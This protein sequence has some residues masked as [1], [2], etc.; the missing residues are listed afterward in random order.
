MPAP[1]PTSTTRSP[2]AK[3]AQRERIAGASERLDGR[4]GN[5]IEQAFVVPEQ[6]RQRTSD[7]EMKAALRIFSDRRVFDLIAWRSEV[8]SR[9]GVVDDIA[10]RGAAPATGSTP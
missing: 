2:G 9:P 5:A 3:M 6:V 4:L 10:V 1:Q 8:T 7:Q